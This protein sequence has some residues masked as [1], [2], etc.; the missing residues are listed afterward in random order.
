MI[1][2]FRRI[3]HPSMKTKTALVLRLVHI[4]VEGQHDSNIVFS[5]ICLRSMESVVEDSLATPQ[6]LSVEQNNIIFIM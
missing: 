5:T 4:L 2:F 3:S 1:G 6:F